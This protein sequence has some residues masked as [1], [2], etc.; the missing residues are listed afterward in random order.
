MEAV[1]H[2]RALH[3]HSYAT[4]H[5]Q[6]ACWELLLPTA[7]HL[8]C[9]LMAEGEQMKSCWGI[10]LRCVMGNLSYTSLQEVEEGGREHAMQL[11]LPIMKGPLQKL[12]FLAFSHATSIQGLD[13]Q[14]R[15]LHSLS[16][17]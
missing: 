7:V 16:T 3:Q 12:V 10:M 4:P 1:C 17:T 2:K 11:S 6:G 9:C 15:Q 5:E 8:A 14:C 13:G